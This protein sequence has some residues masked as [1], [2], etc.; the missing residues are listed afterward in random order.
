MSHILLFEP[1][2]ER[3]PHLIFLLNL[4]DIHCT[5]ARTIEEAINWL[6][7]VRLQVIHFDLFLLSSLEGVDLEKEL[8]AETLNSTTVPVVSIQRHNLPL[9]EICGTEIVSCHSDNLLSCLGELL[10]SENIKLPKEKVQ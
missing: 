1:N 6:S 8:L 2:Q 10:I 5:V 4:A 3:V 7:A 9:P